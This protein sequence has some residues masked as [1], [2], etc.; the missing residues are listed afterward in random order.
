MSLFKGIEE[1]KVSEGG[2]FLTEG[3]YPELEI[4]EFKA[5]QSRKREDFVVVKCKVVQSTG[6]SAAPVGALVDWMVMLRWD[7]ALGHVKGFLAA[8]CG[9]DVSE[10]DEAGTEAAIGEEQPLRGMKISAEA[11][12]VV[13]KSGGTYTKVRWYPH[14]P[15]AVAPPPPPAA[16][17]ASA[18]FGRK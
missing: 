8:A 7:G 5:G 15:A 3:I 6:P 9:I 13:T 17:K 10:V 1:A 11:R 18:M 2:S 12:N 16:P 4:V 14:D